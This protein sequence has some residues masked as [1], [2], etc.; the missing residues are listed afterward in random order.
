[1]VSHMTN[2]ICGNEQM[3]KGETRTPSGARFFF[4]GLAG[5][6]PRPKNDDPSGAEE[7]ISSLS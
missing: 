4:D 3:V 6:P 2:V 1:M 5:L 7:M